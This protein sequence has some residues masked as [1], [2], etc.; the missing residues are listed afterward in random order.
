MQQYEVPAGYKTEA[1][2]MER[3]NMSKPIYGK[4]AAGEGKATEGLG[5]FIAPPPSVESKT[6]YKPPIPGTFNAIEYIT[7]DRN[8]PNFE[9]KGH[10]LTSNYH[11]HIAFRTVADKERAK[12]FKLR[13]HR[14]ANA[15]KY[16]ASWLSY[17]ILWT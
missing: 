16:S 6:G 14:W 7:G 10:G 8:H 11:D 17:H 13:N 12:R 3:Y 4:L 9:L 5:T 1:K 2:I 15:P